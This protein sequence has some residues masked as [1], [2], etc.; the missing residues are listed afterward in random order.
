M[1]KLTGAKK[2]AFL[3]RMAK[4]RRKAKRGNPTS[5]AAAKRKPAKKKATPK[6]KPAAKKK[7]TTSPRPR[8]LTRKA[9]YWLTSAV[10][11][12][13]P[14][15]SK[16]AAQ[17]TMR[18]IKTSGSAPK[19]L[20]VVKNPGIKKL[21]RRG[22]GPLNA[23]YRHKMARVDISRGPISVKTTGRQRKKKRRNSENEAIG[24][25]QTFHGKAPGRI[26]QYDELVRFP[27]HFAE[28]GR[29][30]ELRIELD[31]ENRNFPFTSFG[32]CKVVSTTDGENIYFVG[33]DQRVD[34]DA[35]E[36]GG[37]KDM[38]ELGSCGYICYHTKK[39]F[40]DFEPID[41]FHEFGEEN[42]I[43]PILAYDRLNRKLFLMGGDYRVKREGIVN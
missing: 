4:G 43:K 30:K 13:G 29:L 9:V 14:F 8:K 6:R 35:L 18:D 42:G 34:L 3:E 36:I 24:M 26:V 39:D 1:A 16:K 11:R 2:K 41:Y 17:D 32:D 15:S 22:S 27:E 20:R 40:H 19:N 28:L 10:G 31:R 12:V 37:E 23:Q 5:K 38:V 21:Q 25:Y 33:G 7:K